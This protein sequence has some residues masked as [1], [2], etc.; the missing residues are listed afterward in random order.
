MKL[1][2]TILILLVICA[3]FGAAM[4]GINFYTGPMIEAN[5]AGAE[6]APLL[7][8]M[9]E[10]ASFGSDALIYSSA[11][12]SASSLVNVPASVLSVY[13]EANGLGYVIR[14]TAESS[15]SESPMEIT[16]GIDAEGKI[17]GIQLDSYSDSVDFRDK[18]AN[19]LTSYIGKDSALADVG[20]VSGATF[21][22]SAFKGSV[23]AAMGVL[24]E[25]DLIAA[26]VKSDAQ[27][28]AEMIPALHTGLTSGGLLKA[29]AV[30]A[31]GN[32]VEGYKALNGSGY[33]FMIKNG[34]AT[35]L[36]IVNAAGSCKVY[37]T[38]GADVTEANAAVVEE[39]VAAA[40]LTDFS[41]A[42]EKML[43]DKYVD[44]TEITAIDFDTFG[45]TVYACSFKTGEGTYYAFYSCPLT[46]G[47]H[48]MAI[49]TVID[50]DG[51]IVSQDVK[52]FLFGHGVEYLPVYSEGYGDVSSDAFKTFEEKY[53]GITSETLS[54][55]V[56][57]SGA[58]LS[59]TAVKL[60]TSDAFAVF[61]SI[62]G[63]EQ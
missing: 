9:P 41:A 23:E 22:S 11:D 57:V 48:A 6:L 32:I 8:V 28:L 35:L 51:A 3:V 25:N 31:S 15:Y 49:C 29:E 59:S 20:T 46:Y 63:G 40:T 37:D 7:A 2:K 60:A 27:I 19:Y 62:K 5:N 26:G 14:C 13:K 34:E 12:P 50:E 16:I 47:D 30:A 24:I 1:I 38:T 10:G 43:L 45:N 44:A 52:E 4:F 21:S 39:A 55:D 42:A 58:T 36:A 54:D 18:D 17:C 56:L 33:A 61:N 53:N